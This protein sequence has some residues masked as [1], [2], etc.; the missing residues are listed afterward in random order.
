[1]KIVGLDYGLQTKKVRCSP[2]DQCQH[3]GNFRK[4]SNL[5]PSRG[6]TP[7]LLMQADKKQTIATRQM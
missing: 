5:F 3:P 6:T 7:K 4:S 2:L 1:M